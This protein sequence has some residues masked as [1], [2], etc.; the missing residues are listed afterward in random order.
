MS[1]EALGLI[2]TRGFVAMVEASDAMVK[3]ARVTLVHYEK[4]GGG[5]V[6]TLVRGDVAAV[7]AATEAGAAAAAKVGEV[8]SVHVIPRPHTML[9]DVLPIAVAATPAK[10]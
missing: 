8:V 3:A 7:R 4:I 5:Y 9:E 6:T 2:E 10:K 1:E